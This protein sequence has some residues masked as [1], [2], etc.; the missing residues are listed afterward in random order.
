MGSFDS[1][2]HKCRVGNAHPTLSY[3][4]LAVKLIVFLF[5]TL[6]CYSD[7]TSQLHK[8]DPLGTLPKPCNVDFIDIEWVIEDLT[9]SEVQQ[10]GWNEAFRIKRFRLS[11]PML[12]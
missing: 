8:P 12:R 5:K 7:L 4:D 1:E 6:P 10:S 2:F 11:A 9:K 3:F